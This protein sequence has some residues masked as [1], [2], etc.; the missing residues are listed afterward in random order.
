MKKEQP[1]PS[2]TPFEPTKGTHFQSQPQ[3]ISP[4]F[5]E[6][7]NPEETSNNVKN[8]KNEPTKELLK[9]A[10]EA[11]IDLSKPLMSPQRVLTIDGETVLNLG[12]FSMTI[13]KAKSRKTFLN[14]L[15]MA[16]LVGNMSNGRI[17]SFLPV[18]KLVVVS[19]DTEQGKYHAQQSAKRIQQLIK[20][21]DP[22]N[23]KAYSL[24]KFTPQQR[25][26][27]IEFIIYNT[28]NLGVVFIDGIRDLITSINDEE[29]ATMIT[30]KLM[31][32]TEE[33]DIHINCTLHMNKGD[34]NARG[35]LGTEMLNKSLTTISVTKDKMNPQCSIVEV[36]E[37]R[38]KEPRPFAIGV[39]ESGLPYLISESD[40]SAMK[41]ENRTKKSAHPLDLDNGAHYEIL[42]NKIFRTKKQKTYAELLSAVQNVYDVGVNK[43]KKFITHFDNEDLISSVR[44][45]NKTIYSLV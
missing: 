26:K 30:S 15:L 44:D 14:T 42:K 34:N 10:A 11:E 38:D 28:P 43:A 45:G 33:L 39:D 12:D 17:R 9:M 23:F 40:V 25:L 5:S 13:G 35:H 37:S 8:L 29:Q 41:T 2:T 20:V 6:L 31:K 27:L 18:D 21:N 16:V 3:S 7:N 1:L 4:V 32:W 22:P 19:I 24:R 36:I